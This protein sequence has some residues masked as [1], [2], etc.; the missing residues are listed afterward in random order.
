MQC[1]TAAVDAVAPGKVG[2][3]EGVRA[4]DLAVDRLAEVVQEAAA[5]GDV[6]V[7]ADLAWRASRPVRGLDG[8]HELVLAVARAV[9]EAAEDLSTL[10][11]QAGTARLD[12]GGLRRPP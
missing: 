4:L 10:R 12:G 8:V 5:A 11:V 3:D 1:T 7:G 9:L 6:D 2:A